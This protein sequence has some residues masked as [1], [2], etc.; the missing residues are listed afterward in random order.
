MKKTILILAAVVGTFY[1]TFAGNGAAPAPE[2][3][4]AQKNWL[5]KPIKDNDVSLEI[6]RLGG[7]VQMYLYSQNMKGVDL[8]YVEKSKDPTNGFSR[9]KT[10]K[11]SDHQVKSKN[12]ISVVDDSPYD[13]NTDSYYRIR[14]VSASGSTKIYPVVGLAPVMSIEPETVD[15]SK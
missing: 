13:S 5:F 11:V 3:V 2:S 1:T 4:A 7:N 8:I 10:V 14:T 6:E 15:N 12:Y 9:C